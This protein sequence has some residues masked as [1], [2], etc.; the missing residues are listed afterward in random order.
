MPRKKR[1]E[2]SANE[3][4]EYILKGASWEGAEE[5]GVEIL[6]RCMALHVYARRDGEEFAEKLAAN[7][8]SR[9]IDWAH[10]PG[11]S[12]I[13]AFASLG[14]KI[15]DGAYPFLKELKDGDK[16]V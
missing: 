12:T 13:L 6:A 10:E 7:I 15:K 1:S 16:A 11:N 4:M 2:M 5:V 8:S 3:R 14:Q 9:A